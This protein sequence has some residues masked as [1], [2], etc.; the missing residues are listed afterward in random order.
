MFALILAGWRKNARATTRSPRADPLIRRPWMP[1]EVAETTTTLDRRSGLLRR[2]WA[3]IA[4]TG[5]AVV[6]GAVIAIVVAFGVG[7][8]VITLTDLL[9]T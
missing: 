3:A 8:L 1:V 7:Y 6:I 2:A 4:S 9:K 5:L